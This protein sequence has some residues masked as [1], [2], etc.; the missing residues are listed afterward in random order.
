MTNNEEAEVDVLEDVQC[1]EQTEEGKDISILVLSI[2]IVSLHKESVRMRRARGICPKLSTEMV[3]QG[4]DDEV[5]VLGPCK[6]GVLE[7]VLPCGMVNEATQAHGV[8]VSKMHPTLGQGMMGREGDGV[9]VVKDDTH[10]FA[11]PG[12]GQV[13]TSLVGHSLRCCQIEMFS[14]TG[15]IG[16]SF[17]C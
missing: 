10:V 5:G 9:G 15:M 1:C 11:G 16:L 12:A 17:S 7:E 8:V 14:S 2:A 13:G 3:E 4:G 6:L